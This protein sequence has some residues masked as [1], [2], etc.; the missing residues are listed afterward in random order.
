M[1]HKRSAE[2]NRRLKKLAENSCWPIGAWYSDKKNRYYRFSASDIG[3]A[4]WLKRYCN[5]RLR[6]RKD[7][8][9]RG[10]YHKLTEYWWALF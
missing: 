2:D 8:Y 3:D 4:R 7:L 9:Q 6:R 1:S 10:L 5:R